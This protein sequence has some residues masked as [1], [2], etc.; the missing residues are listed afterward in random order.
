MSNLKV[1]EAERSSDLGRLIASQLNT[2][3]IKIKMNN[4]ADSESSIV[5]DQSED[6]KNSDVLFVHKFFSVVYSGNIDH[7]FINSQIYEMILALDFVK[8]NGAKRIIALIP[9]LPYVRQDKRQS[10]NYSGPF[11][12]FTK[13]LKEV[14][15]D[16]I[17]ACDL[18]SLA[19][20]SISAVTLEN[21]SLAGFWESVITKYVISR[22]KKDNL[23]I[24]SPDQGGLERARMIASALG[25][26]LAFVK[27]SRVATDYA[28]AREID[29]NVK[30]KVVLLVDDIID[31][32]RTATGACDLL[33]EAGATKVLGFFSH[34]VLSTGSQER[35]VQGRFESIFIAD[36]ISYG[37]AGLHEKF[38]LLTVNEFLCG[39]VRVLIDKISKN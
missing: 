37:S 18:H 17:L 2:S 24:V 16:F 20:F 31:T 22:E 34:A 1:V 27:K 30:G 35:L 10:D 32:A 13:L 25:I 3:L 19:A 36:T 12:L 15:V 29:G 28:V 8:S 14:G 6:F 7:H 5:F 4:F 38:K 21:I 9:Y 33:L 26:D 39:R 11:A 23:C